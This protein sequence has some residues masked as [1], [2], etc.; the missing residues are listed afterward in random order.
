[1]VNLTN[2]PLDIID[3]TTDLS[4]EDLT[5]LKDGGFVG[6]T[7]YIGNDLSTYQGVTNANDKSFLFSSKVT[8]IYS[9]GY[10]FCLNFIGRVLEEGRNSTIERALSSELRK[11]VSYFKLKTVEVYIEMGTMYVT[12]EGWLPNEILSVSFSIKSR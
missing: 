4:E 7:R 10:S 3:T 5:A 6:I 12:V 9:V 11:N 8:E 2:M 1:M